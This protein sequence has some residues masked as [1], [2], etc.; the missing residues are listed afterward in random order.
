METCVTFSSFLR[1]TICPRI[2]PL[3]V[4]TGRFAQNEARM[5]GFSTGRYS[6]RP[7]P[8]SDGPASL[9]GTG[10]GGFHVESKTSG[11]LRPVIQVIRLDLHLR[12]RSTESNDPSI[13]HFA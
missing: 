5:T 10:A 13:A 8:A 2:R 3:V 9:K 12:R 6:K 7:R 1:P 4:D 11:P